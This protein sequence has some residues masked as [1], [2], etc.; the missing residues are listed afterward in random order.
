MLVSSSYPRGFLF[1]F[2]FEFSI[3]PKN[4][5][6]EAISCDNVPG[7]LSA[8]LYHWDIFYISHFKEMLAQH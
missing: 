4:N 7:L 8:K 3:S 5:C 6:L 2:D 1:S